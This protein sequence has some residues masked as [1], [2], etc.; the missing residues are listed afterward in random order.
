MDEEWDGLFEGPYDQL[1]GFLIINGASFDDAQDATGDAILEAFRLMRDDHAKWLAVCD[2]QAWI[3]S[4][5]LRK[6]KRPPGPR[7]RP[8]IKDADVPDRPVPGVGHD[9]MTVQTQLVV[10]AL[11]SLDPEARKVMAFS[12]DGVPTAEIA[13]ALGIGE[14]RVRDIKKR[15]REKLKSLLGA[16]G[17]R[18]A[19]TEGSEKP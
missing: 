19:G 12:I 18:S 10:Q 7:I 11:R 16:D 17:G 3:R 9:E 13:V 1:I 6:Y 15:A 4:V 2:K 5:A 8:L 14:Q